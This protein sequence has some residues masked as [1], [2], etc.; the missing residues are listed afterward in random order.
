[1]LITLVKFNFLIRLLRLLE[2]FMLWLRQGREPLGDS[3]GN[4]SVLYAV[5][6][7]NTR[8]NGQRSLWCYDACY[9]HVLWFL[10]KI[11]VKLNNISCIIYK[12]PTRCNFGQYCLLTTARTLCMFRTLSAPIIRSTENC[13]NSQWCV[14]C[15]KAWHA[16]LAVTTVFSTP[17]DGRRKRPKHVECSCS[18]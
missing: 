6:A 15:C 1:M 12:E 8:V 2:R 18:C 7:L 11:P 10:S 13:S 16:P 4:V 9:Q 14:S 17:D 3:A 5:F